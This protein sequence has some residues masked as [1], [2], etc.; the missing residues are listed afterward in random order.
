MDV[1]RKLTQKR[2]KE[3]HPDFHPHVVNI[4]DLLY[5]WCLP[6]VIPYIAFAYRSP[7]LQDRLWR[8]GR[9]FKDGQVVS[10]NRRRV[11][12]N[13][14]GNQSKHCN[15]VEGL[16]ASLAVDIALVRDRAWLPDKDPMWSLVPAAAVLASPTG[17]VICGAMW[18]SPRDWAHIEWTRK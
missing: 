11:V 13:L 10:V 18:D 9:T 6:G 15:E 16:P 17:S 2:L 5:D 4:L 12:T 7:K 14:R 1:Y 8:K 3:V